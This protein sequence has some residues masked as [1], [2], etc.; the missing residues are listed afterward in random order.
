MELNLIHGALSVGAIGL[1]TE[2]TALCDLAET[3]AL[4][5]ECRLERF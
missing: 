3:E 1:S 5:S 4:L 2:G